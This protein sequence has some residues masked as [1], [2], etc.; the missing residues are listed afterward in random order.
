MERR[1]NKIPPGTVIGGCRI[2]ADLGCGGM[3]IVYRA[4]DEKLHRSVAIKLMHGTEHMTTEKS[5]FLRE[6]VAI[7]KLDHPGIIRI[8][9]YGEFEGLPYF[10]MELVQGGS[11]KDFIARH[12]LLHSGKHSFDELKE[13]GYIKDEPPETPFFLRNP[14]ANLLHDPE[15][16][17]RVRELVS[18]IAEGLEMAHSQ[19]IVHRDLK[20][21]NIMIGSQGK[22]KILDFGLAKSPG[23]VNVTQTSQ[24]LGTISYAAPEQ[25]MG[26]RGNI[27]L[28][29]DVY[30]LGVIFYELLTM[31]HPISEE[32]P[33]AII[34]AVTQGSVRPPRDLNPNIPDDLE[35]I[36]LTCVEKDP[37]K[38]FADGEE[39]V[40]A[41]RKPHSA[42]HWFSG[43]K[44]L[45]SGWFSPKD[46]AIAES[47]GKTDK[48]CEPVSGDQNISNEGFPRKTDRK[49]VGEK[50]LSEAKTLFFHQFNFLEALEKLKQSFD[51]DP[52][53]PNILF[54]LFLALNSIREQSSIKGYLSRSESLID[55]NDEKGWGKFLF[56]KEIFL[57]RNYDEARKQALRL[58]QLFPEDQD[59]QIGL[60]FALEV[61]GNF[62]EAIRVGETLARNSPENNLIAI[63]LSECYLSVWDHQKALDIMIERVRKFPNFLNLRLKTYQIFFV[64][65]KFSE[66]DREIDY[67]LE[68][69]PG[70]AFMYLHKGRIMLLR[71]ELDQA[72]DCFRQM[73]GLQIDDGMKAL[74]FYH[75]YRLLVMMEKTEEAEKFLSEGGKQKCKMAFLSQAELWKRISDEPLSGIRRELGSEDWA[76]RVLEYARKVCFDS[77]DLLSY[78]MGN[79]GCTSVFVLSE[80]GKYKHHEIFSHFNFEENDELFTQLW[81]SSFP[82]SPFIDGNGNILRTA[83]HKIDH[84]PGGGIACLSL[85]EP[86]KSGKGAFIYCRLN[87]GVLSERET[88]KTFS[89]PPLPLLAIRRHAFLVVI[90]ERLKVEKVSREPLESEKIGRFKVFTYFPRLVGGEIIK[91]EINLSCRNTL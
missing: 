80:D 43:L 11:L 70:S 73:V 5:R 89:L 17:N 9:S 75:L 21:S 34:A 51:L 57:K 86:W 23:D 87:D 74:G 20:P 69:D 67:V 38:R 6:A 15:Y 10:I 42:V 49:F 59:I 4:M 40:S 54:C 41:L 64:L 37:F 16:P 76:G 32:D 18:E 90:P 63:G 1:A 50:L 29:T 25:F 26:S 35:R 28:R 8:Y 83:F 56:A 68:R 14:V 19:G 82:K 2:E 44:G 65:G 13:G 47:C 79:F 7:A 31:T 48:H 71:G 45:F 55:R 62:P 30:S 39:L 24:F 12:R 84:D 61:L 46:L 33:A 27:S 78:T 85:S 77:A 52:A 88:V 58:I 36:I 72:Y 66:A 91:L 60:F 3:G 22:P 81:V 53:N